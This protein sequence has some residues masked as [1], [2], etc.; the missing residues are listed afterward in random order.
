MMRDRNLEAA[1]AVVVAAGGAPP[2]SPVHHYITR[3][4]RPGDFL[5]AADGGA[6]VL[7]HLKLKPDVVLG[8]FDSLEGEP[9]DLAREGEKPAIESH[10]VKKDKTDT[11][12]AVEYLMNLKEPPEEIII[13]GATGNRLDHELGTLLYAASLSSGGGPAISL[14]DARQEAFF[15]TS[16]ATIDAP[17]ET[18][19]SFIPLTRKVHG[20]Y[21]EGFHYPLKG[22]TLRW[23]QTLGISNVTSAETARVRIAGEGIL[24]AVV[25]R[26]PNR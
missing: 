5:L 25:Q 18:T 8:D 13:C 14:V 3:I 20:V 6:G 10:P 1:R 23:E 9:E 26:E 24:L 16:E 4:F 17:P 11:Q 22:G 7:K 21:L 2:G 15:V 19:V 12:L